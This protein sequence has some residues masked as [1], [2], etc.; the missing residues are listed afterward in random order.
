MKIREVV[1][2]E[3]LSEAAL[4]VSS[5]VGVVRNARDTAH[6][7]HLLGSAAPLEMFGVSVV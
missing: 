6:I 5:K 1:V 7:I 4:L 3:E 2:K